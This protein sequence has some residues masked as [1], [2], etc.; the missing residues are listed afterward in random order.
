[1][2][3]LATAYLGL[4]AMIGSA[5]AAW[6]AEAE[7]LDD[8]EAAKSTAEKE[9]KDLLL[10][11]TGSDWCPWCI[12][13]KKEVFSTEA[14]RKE[15]PKYFVLVEL[16]LPRQKKLPEKLK[17]QN[18]KLSKEYQVDSFPT[19]CLTDARGRTY[20]KTGYQDG[21]AE[22]YLEL[23]SGLRARK[24]ARDELFAKAEK[25]KGVEK[26]KL[27]N[28]ALEGLEKDDACVGYDDISKQIIALDSENQA[29]LKLKYET[30]ARLNEVAKT[31]EGG[32]LDAA[33]AKL[34][35]LLQEA[36]LS[37]GAKQASYFLK[38][39]ILMHK[40]DQ[41][42]ALTALQSARDADPKTERAREIALVIE[43]LKA[44]EKAPA[45]E[46]A[47]TEEKR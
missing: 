38:A 43:R 23:L 45:A 8:F 17:L 41:A 27:L 37:G 34:Q 3:N 6:S 4:L 12:K 16:D 11:F 25:A 26:A 21:G 44:E 15:A 31:A 7:W 10:D 40:K 28:Q 46:K 22:R 32:E 19:V 14:F 33:L 47:K 29:G 35:A 39:M 36:G 9:G 2:R 5:G 1:M 30:Q 18:E 20:A 42:G 24:T 13:L